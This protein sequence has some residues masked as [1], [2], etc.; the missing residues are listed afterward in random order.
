MGVKLRA[1]PDDFGEREELAQVSWGPQLTTG[2]CAATR[3]I[4]AP[5][6]VQ[7]PGARLE[8]VLGVLHE[9]GHLVF[10]HPERGLDV[11]EAWFMPWEWAVVRHATQGDSEFWGAFYT[12]ATTV[13]DLKGGPCQEVISWKQPWRSGWFRQGLSFCQY[14]GALRRDGTITW[15]AP[16]WR[17]APEYFHRM[18]RDRD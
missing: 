1:T 11:D 8:D 3:T 17:Q 18:T 7:A 6:E 9:L 5:G 2:L 14:T 13:R 16:D 4:W 10:W 12:G 15:S